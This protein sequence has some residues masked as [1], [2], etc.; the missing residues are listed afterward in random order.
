M[1]ITI[2]VFIII[3]TIVLLALIIMYYKGMKFLQRTTY[4]MNEQMGMDEM[5]R[6]GGNQLFK[7]LVYFIIDIILLIIYLI[8]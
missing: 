8:I 7:I 5:K 1:K 4:V 2:L 6:Y 3:I